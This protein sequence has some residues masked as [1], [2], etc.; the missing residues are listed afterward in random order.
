MYFYWQTICMMLFQKA[1]TGLEF[2]MAGPQ[3][4]YYLI[5]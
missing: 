5:F 4:I 3:C 2:A 1:L